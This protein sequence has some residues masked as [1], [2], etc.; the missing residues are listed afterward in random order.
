MAKN[1]HG[2]KSDYQECKRGEFRLTVSTYFL[3]GNEIRNVMQ[4]CAR[5]NEEANNHGSFKV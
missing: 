3:K 5:S 1:K 4:D 2:M